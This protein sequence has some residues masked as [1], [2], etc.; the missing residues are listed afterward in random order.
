MADHYPFLEKLERKTYPPFGECIYC[1]SDSDLGK[2]HIVPHGLGGTFVLP[3]SSCS[4]CAKI[5]SK[6]ELDVLRGELWPVR[7]HRA[8]QSRRKHKYAPN[9]YPL[10][11]VR[12]GA[13][14]SIQLPLK[15]YPILVPFLDFTPPRK[16]IGAPSKSGI[17]VQGVV[18]LA[19]GPDPVN[20]LR[21]TGAQTIRPHVRTHPVQF[22]RMIAKI[23]YSMAAAVGSLHLISGAS[24]IRDVILGTNP[25]IG[26]Y[27]GTTT[28]PLVR[29][30]NLLHRIAIHAM[31]D[32]GQLVAE[33]QL[34]SD[35]SAP[36]YGV[37]LGE[38]K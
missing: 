21:S 9:L 32:I 12:N 27:V 7:I 36:C 26:D 20:V 33:V 29:H 19:F 1:G 17:D 5:T 15:D 31:P 6:F 4:S 37:L 30:D 24:P 25:C 3:K 35:S 10:S 8:L 18:T 28:E 2:E 16:A 14:E 13:E 34:F 11:I 38:L 22:A 23:G